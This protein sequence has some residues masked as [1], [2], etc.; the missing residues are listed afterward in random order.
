VVEQAAILFKYHE[1]ER[2]QLDLIRR[3]WKG[4][5]ALPAVIPSTRRARSRTMARI[6]RVNVCRSSSTR[7]RSPSFVD[8]FRGKKD[9]EPRTSRSGG[10]AGE[11]DGRP[12]DGHPPRRRRLRRRL[13]VV[14]PGT[15]DA[16]DP[17]SRPRAMTPST[18]RIP[19]GRCGRSSGSAAAS[20]ALRRRGRLLRQRGTTGSSGGWDVH[21]D[22]EHGIGVTPVVRYLDEDDLD[23]DDEVEPEDRG[24]GGNNDVPTRG[25]VVAADADAGPDRP[26][27]LRAAGRAALRRVP[28]A[29]R[30]RLGAGQTSARR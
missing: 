13:R 29:L 2:D 4:R 12:P 23:D 9:D 8:G 11:Q 18:A 25:Q 20:S 19:T 17:P 10:V 24:L 28:A 16:R 3:Y 7:W 5:Q 22:R 26:D 27:D 14:L 1:A 30:D 15:P 21:R 6:A